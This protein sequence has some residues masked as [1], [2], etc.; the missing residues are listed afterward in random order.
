MDMKQL[1]RDVREGKV[2]AL[3]LLE[4]VKRQSE[5]NSRQAKAIE[6]LQGQLDACLKQL[7]DVKAKQDGKPTQKLDE[8]YSNKAEDRRAARKKRKKD[9]RNK[10]K[11]GRKSKPAEAAGEL[12]FELGLG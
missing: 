10:T 11:R 8:P 2:D 7:K 5:E 4:I 6:K 12:A 3:R 1:E 9:L